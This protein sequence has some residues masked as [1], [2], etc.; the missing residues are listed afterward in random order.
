[1]NFFTTTSGCRALTHKTNLSSNQQSHVN[2][3]V[4][5]TG[6]VQAWSNFFLWQQ[7]EQ[8][9]SRSAVTK[10]MSKFIWNINTTMNN[11]FYILVIL[12]IKFYLKIIIISDL[13]IDSVDQINI[14][15]GVYGA[16]CFLE[17][18]LYRYMLLNNQAHQ[19][20]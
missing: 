17:I 16:F 7:H 14:L 6:K 2:L 1:M 9:F 4:T 8:L 20:T 5:K 19:I 18:V 15:V 10:R 3:Q 11:S 12:S 13:L